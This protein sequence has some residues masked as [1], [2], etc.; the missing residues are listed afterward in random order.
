MSDIRLFELDQAKGT[1]LELV[2][3]QAKFEKDL[4]QLVESHMETFLNINFL[5]SE[6]ITS[7]GGRIDSL[8]LDENGCPVTIEYKRHTNEN[9][10]NQGLFY[11]D[12]LIDQKAEFKLLVMEKL[13]SEAADNLEWEGARLICIA[14]DF[15][16]YDE[17]AIKQI[18]KNI[19]LMRYK[20]FG[21][22]LFLLELVN[23]HSSN[24]YS[25]NPAAVALPEKTVE[26]TSKKERKDYHQNRIAAASE[27][28][29]KLYEHICEFGLLLGDD[30]QRKELKFYTPLK[31]IKN[32]ASVQVWAPL[33]DPSLRIY[34]NLNPESVELK[35][36]MVSDVRGKG[37]WGI[38]DLEVIVRNIEELDIAKQLIKLSFEQN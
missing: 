27:E 30:V 12:W 13:S 1:A 9:V 3:A 32:F 8:G 10:I 7:N 23:S 15:T 37:H 11:Y 20:Y 33:Q 34:L 25:P 29:L 26:E 17:H 24:R 36:G 22:D 21:E 4:Q 28:L 14:S 31:K 5:A 2:R 35:K 16:K 6:F 38:G 19:E 18:D